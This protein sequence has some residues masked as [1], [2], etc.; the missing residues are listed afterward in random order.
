LLG[1]SPLPMLLATLILLLTKG[2]ILYLIGRLQKMGTRAARCFAFSLPQGGEFAF[3]L[4]TAATGY[5][6]LPRNRAD[7]LI[8]VVTLSMIATPILA[9]INDRW[10]TPWLDRSP[11]RPFDNIEDS[12]APVIIA[13]FGRFGQA[14]GR[15]LRVRGVAFTALDSDAA[16]VDLVRRFGNRAYYGDASRLDLLEA[17]GAARARIFVL[18]IDDVETSIRVAELVRKRFSHLRLIARARNR[19]HAHRLMDIGVDYLVREVFLSAM[20]VARETLAQLGADPEQ[21]RNAAETFRKHDE[22]TLARQQ[23]VYHSEEQLV[24]SARQAVQELEQ[25]LRTDAETP[26]VAPTGGRS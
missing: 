1:D 4:F 16:Q 8:L 12:H 21:A 10:L 6:L 5:G 19:Y 22:H 14:T 25:L 15:L 26:V 23:A 20:D 13:G 2:S 3:V 9:M 11:P 17:A 18:A 7:E 24:E